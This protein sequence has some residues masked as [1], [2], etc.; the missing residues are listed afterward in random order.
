MQKNDTLN[1]TVLREEKAEAEV[2]EVCIQTVICIFFIFSQIFF[3]SLLIDLVTVLYA[4]FN[5]RK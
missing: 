1:L 4:V 2:R 5:G 3:P